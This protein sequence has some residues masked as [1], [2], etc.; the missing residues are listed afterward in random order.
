MTRTKTYLT[1]I[2][3]DRNQDEAHSEPPP[4]LPPLNTLLK[5]LADCNREALMTYYVI[6]HLRGDIVHLPI[7][8]DDFIAAE[9]QTPFFKKCLLLVPNSNEK[10]ST[11]T[12]RLKKSI[13]VIWPGLTVSQQ[14]ETED[15]IENFSLNQIRLLKE[16]IR[17]YRKLL[18]V[19]WFQ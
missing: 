8:Y 4:T 2:K 9:H 18:K 16:F 14:A 1:S 11:Y 5:S 3:I 19:V 17:V 12:P 15:L 13:N 7:S 6:T 10:E